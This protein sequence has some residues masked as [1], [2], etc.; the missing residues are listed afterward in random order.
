[1]ADLMSVIIAVGI[2]AM[3]KHHRVEVSAFT[4]FKRRAE[5]RI[6]KVNTVDGSSPVEVWFRE[7]WSWRKSLSWRRVVGLVFVA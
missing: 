2:D 1:M 5:C 6:P 7:M 4:N 3:K